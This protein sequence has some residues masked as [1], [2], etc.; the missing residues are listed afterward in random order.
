MDDQSYEDRRQY[1]RTPT[2]ISAEINSEKCHIINISFGGLLVM[3]TY[4]GNV[5]QE[6]TVDFN[7]NGHRFVKNAVIRDVYSATPLGISKPGKKKYAYNIHLSFLDPIEEEH[8]RWME[9]ERI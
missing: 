3:T 1:V 4:Y 9:S 2:S 7:Y 5:G 8:L 6:V